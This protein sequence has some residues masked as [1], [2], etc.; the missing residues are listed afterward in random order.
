[1]NDKQAEKP[2]QLNK[3]KKRQAES[4][5]QD[6]KTVDVNFF[7]GKLPKL[8]VQSNG[9]IGAGQGNKSRRAEIKIIFG[10]LG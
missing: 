6:G 7:A 8:D 3:N 2:K 4:N 10:H 9:K 1:M 5:K